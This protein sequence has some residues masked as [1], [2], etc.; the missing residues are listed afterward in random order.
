MLK[1]N[2]DATINFTRGKRVNIW[3]GR[4]AFYIDLASSACRPSVSHFTNY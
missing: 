4:E 3:K 2:A 1:V